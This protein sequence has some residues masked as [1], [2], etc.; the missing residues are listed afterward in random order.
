MTD[1]YRCTA[2]EFAWLDVRQ[3][4]A[5]KRRPTDKFERQVA[6]TLPTSELL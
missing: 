2:G 6:D 3:L 1:C 5:G 4:M